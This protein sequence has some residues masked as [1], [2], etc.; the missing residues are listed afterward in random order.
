MSGEGVNF[1][2]GIFMTFEAFWEEDYLLLEEE[3]LDF[4]KYV[5]LVENHEDVWSMKLANLLLLIGSSI[6]SF[7]KNSLQY[8]LNI[9]IEENSPENNNNPQRLSE[10]EDYQNKLDSNNT[11]MGD[12]REVFNEFYMLSNE[13]VYVLRNKWEFKPFNKWSE[14]KSPEWWDVYRK[15]KHDRIKHRERCTLKI[16]LNALGAL[17]LLNIYHVESRRKLMEQRKIIKS[18]MNVGYL[19]KIMDERGNINEINPILAKTYLFGYV[20]KGSHGHYYDSPWSLL[21]P[22]DPNNDYHF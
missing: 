13:P 19:L 4:I 7:F 10:Y 1:T 17:F 8:C 15:L 16:T 12:F 21:D 5:P 22:S 6:D 18:N 3:F 9:L 20:F 2:G 11:N 14:D